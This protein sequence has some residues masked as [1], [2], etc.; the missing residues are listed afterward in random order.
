VLPAKRVFVTSDD[1]PTAYGGLA[2]ADTLCQGAAVAAGLTGLWK[3]WLSDS[4][5]S[6][7]ERLAH[8]AGPYQTI[9]GTTVA[10]NW[11]ML[12]SGT[13]RAPIDRDE[14]GATRDRAVFTDTKADGTVHSASE[15]CADWSADGGSQ[16]SYA[17]RSVAVDSTWT[18]SPGAYACVYAF[19][20]YCVE[21]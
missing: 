14:F 16:S 13:L 7:A 4:T 20:L 1:Y 5:G 3:A 11:D 2:G 17:G 10:D 15:H 12:T 19:A 21:Q 9:P 8:H 18:H 6:A